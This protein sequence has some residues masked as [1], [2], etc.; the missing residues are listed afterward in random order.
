LLAFSV[1]VCSLAVSVPGLPLQRPHTAHRPPCGHAAVAAGCRRNEQSMNEGESQPF[2]AACANT[3]TAAATRLL[4]CRRRGAWRHSAMMSSGRCACHSPVIASGLRHSR[5]L[6]T[7]TADH[8]RP[9]A[10]APPPSHTCKCW[11]RLC[12]GRFDVVGRLSLN[13]S[14]PSPPLPTRTQRGDRPI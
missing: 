2:A 4:R 7:T 1:V 3:H 8:R 9:R 5:H 12:V 14:P 10:Q 11:Y 6:N 13:F